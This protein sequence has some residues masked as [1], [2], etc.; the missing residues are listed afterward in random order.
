[1]GVE[2]GGFGRDFLEFLLGFGVVEVVG[3]EGGECGG[4]V[5]DDVA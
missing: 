3:F 4:V 5:A 2:V 1:M